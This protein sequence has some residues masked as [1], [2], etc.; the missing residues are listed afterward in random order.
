MNRIDQKLVVLEGNIGVPIGAPPAA[1]VKHM[2]PIGKMDKDGGLDVVMHTDITEDDG[3]ADAELVTIW[4]KT[5]PNLDGSDWRNLNMCWAGS[6]ADLKTRIGH[7]GFEYRR[8]L[9]VMADEY[10]WGEIIHSG[11]ASG[12]DIP[13]HIRLEPN[14]D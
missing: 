4:V 5:G 7:F 9:R 8:G 13:I 11:D 12:A 14:Y 10:V 3:S 1:E 6:I 2:F